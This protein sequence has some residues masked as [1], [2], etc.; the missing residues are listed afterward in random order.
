M[1]D[2]LTILETAV[3]LLRRRYDEGGTVS[4]EDMNRLGSCTGAINSFIK[5][6][7]TRA[8]ADELVSHLAART[9][10]E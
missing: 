7:R 3:N 5:N 9:S 10:P 8:K 1:N 4:S 6:W 2:E